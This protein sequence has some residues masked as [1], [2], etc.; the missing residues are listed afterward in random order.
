VHDNEFADPAEAMAGNLHQIHDKIITVLE[1]RVVDLRPEVLHWA[2]FETCL[3]HPTT[4]FQCS[5]MSH[6]NA[7]LMEF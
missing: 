6:S 2:C 4:F 1:N 7:G 3:Q 5:F